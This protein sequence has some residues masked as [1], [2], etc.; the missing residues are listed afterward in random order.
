MVQGCKLRCEKKSCTEGTINDSCKLVKQYQ[1]AKAFIESI[2]SKAGTE[3]GQVPLLIVPGNHDV[4]RHIVTQSQKKVRDTYDSAS[5]EELQKDDYSWQDAI[6]RQNQ[7]FKFVKSL[8]NH[9]CVKWDNKF[10]VPYGVVDAC[11]QK[12]GFTGL[13]TSGPHVRIK[14]DTNYGLE[15]INLIVYTRN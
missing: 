5:V 4:N 11:G 3:L 14:K 9:A 2:A 10:F 15:K 12:I 6:K 7:W 1:S 13:N 8:S